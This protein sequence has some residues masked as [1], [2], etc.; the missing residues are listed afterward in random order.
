MFSLALQQMCNFGIVCM[1]L[2]I[3]GWRV[4]EEEGMML[5]NVTGWYRKAMSSFLSSE[6]PELLVT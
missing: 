4:I 3:I 2:Q 6:F 5:P 1:V